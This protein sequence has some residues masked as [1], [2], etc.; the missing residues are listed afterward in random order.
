MKA[1]TI[2]IICLLAF[3]LLLGCSQNEQAATLVNTDTPTPVTHEPI[4]IDILAEDMLT[5]EPVTPV[6]THT[7]P[8]TPTPEPTNTPV[9]TPFSIAWL[10]DT[11]N[12]TLHF[13]DVFF[14]VSDW[15]MASAAEYNV[16]LFVHSGDVTDNGYSKEQWETANT[17]LEPI[18]GAYPSLIVAGN[19]DIKAGGDNE[20]FSSFLSQ[21]SILATL[22]DGQTYLDGAASYT[23]FSAGGTDFVVVGI[24]WGIDKTATYEWASSV[25]DAYPQRVGIIVSHS[26]LESDGTF[27]GPGSRLHKN[28]VAKCPNVR[29]VLCGHYRE[30]QQKLDYYDDDGD[31]IPD[32]YVNT[33]MFNFQEDKEHGLGC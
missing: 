25:F 19:H 15:I 16:Q 27:T 8:P 9:P 29:L 22:K 24:S 11:Q 33:L 20:S 14:S 17:A 7:P 30:S 12:Y 23:L 10:S 18:V 6:P 32:R 13:P 4:S 1:H 31:N 3:L 26:V 28:V 21:P 2:T 5:I